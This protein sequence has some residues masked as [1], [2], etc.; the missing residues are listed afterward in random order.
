M[1]LQVI[2]STDGK[3][4]YVLLPV[5]AYEA[6]KSQIDKIVLEEYE[7]FDVNDYVSSPIA[8]MRIKANLTQKELAEKLNVSQAYIS[9]LES[10]KKVSAKTLAKVKKTCK[11]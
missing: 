11:V 9:K 3:V 8:L 10:Q 6:L 4:E 5:K 1:S 2:K 7:I